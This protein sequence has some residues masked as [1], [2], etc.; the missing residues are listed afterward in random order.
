MVKCMKFG[1][2]QEKSFDMRMN[3]NI[4]ISKN[5][6]GSSNEIIPKCVQCGCK[7]ISFTGENY[8]VVH[9]CSKCISKI[10]LTVLFSKLEIYC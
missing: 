8:E 10:G 4:N 9:C 1:F 2:P 7:V 6:Q 5:I 3:N